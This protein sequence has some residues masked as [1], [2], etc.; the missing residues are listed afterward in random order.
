MKRIAMLPIVFA[1]ALSFACNADNRTTRDDST[2]G[3]TGD[4]VSAGD[5]D[6][7]ENI[8]IAGMAEVE[9]GKM[10]MERGANA[11]VK[12][13]GDMM[14]TDHS[15]AGAEL[16]QIAM[17][18]S[19]PTPTSLDEKHQDLRTKLSNLRGAEFDREYMNAMVDGHEDVVDRLQ[20]RAS[21]DRLGDDKGS[22]R[23]ERSDNPVEAAINQ[24]SAK[25]LPTTRHHL[26]EAKR[27][28][29]GLGRNLTQRY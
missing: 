1:A 2:V 27:I 22:V 21:E 9:L 12:K 11:E 14:V 3:T 23:P 24:W 26:D 13:F 25:T 17:K 18:H 10:A 15:K 19:I 4:A 16:K 6:F 7:V 28:N 20:T 5:R 8:T 29:D